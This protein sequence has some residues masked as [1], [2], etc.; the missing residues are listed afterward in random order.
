VNAAVISAVLLMVLASNALVIAGGAPRLKSCYLFLCA[1]LV[2]IFAVPFGVFV[3]MP[4][5]WVVAALLVAIPVFFSG[6]V[7]SDT[8]SRA[9][10]AHVALGSNMLGSLLGGALEA[11]SLAIGIRALS[12]VALVIYAGSAFLVLRRQAALAAAP[13]PATAAQG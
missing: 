3:A 10:S 4:G 6:L 13:Q 1:S 5:G 8:F 9:P 11:A 7:F 2:V 12:L